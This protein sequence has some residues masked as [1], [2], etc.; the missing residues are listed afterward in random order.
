M[1]PPMSTNGSRPTTRAGRRQRVADNTAD[2]AKVKSRARR[3]R[4]PATGLYVSKLDEAVIEHVCDAIRA[5]AYLETAVAAAGVRLNSF[6]DWLRTGAAEPDADTLEA[7]LHHAV[8]RAL[9]EFEVDA[10]RVLSS[11]NDWRAHAHILERRLP[12]RWGKVDRLDVADASGKAA[13][14]DEFNPEVYTT[15]EL[16]T[17]RALLAKSTG[18]DV[19]DAEA[20]EVVELDSRRALSP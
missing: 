18:G 9:A 10:V 14:L 8:T 12:D 15:E 13:R 20:A 4:D 5:G 19:V 1:I 3:P 7:A 11:S 6:R 16:E 17:L 2:P